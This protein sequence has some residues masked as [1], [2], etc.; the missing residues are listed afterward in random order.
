MCAPH[1]PH[2]FLHPTSS[3]TQP[4][5]NLH[6][7]RMTLPFWLS[8]FEL[9]LCSSSGVSPAP[10]LFGCFARWPARRHRAQPPPSR[11][12]SCSARATRRCGVPIGGGPTRLA[13]APCRV[14]VHCPS[15]AGTLGRVAGHVWLANVDCVLDARWLLTVEAIIIGR[16]EFLMSYTSRALHSFSCLSYVYSNT[17]STGKRALGYKSV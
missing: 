13:T 6:I 16:L 2:A 9:A 15:H 12:E 3:P 17:P 14:L 10:R 4:Q 1:L 11:Q 7:I 8:F 5:R